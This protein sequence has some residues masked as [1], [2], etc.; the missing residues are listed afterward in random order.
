MLLASSLTVI[1]VG[2]L[3][4]LYLFVSI[5]LGHVTATA[6]TLGQAED[7]L[8]LIADTASEASEVELVSAGDVTAIKMTMPATGVDKD[9][10]GYPDRFI[11]LGVSKRMSPQWGSGVRIW[12]YT[13]NSTGAFPT[14]GTYFWRAKRNDDANPTAAD[15][16]NSSATYYGG[17]L[18]FQ[19]LN[20]TLVAVSSTDQTLTFTIDSAAVIGQAENESTNANSSATDVRGEKVQRVVKWRN[21]RR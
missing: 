6:L 14:T 17:F 4:S 10:D 18:K 19:M 9:N 21:W 15:R 12:F 8:K 5:R 2:V 7:A 20:H 11:P 16:D 13:G 3:C 1:I